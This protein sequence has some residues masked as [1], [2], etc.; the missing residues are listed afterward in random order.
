MGFDKETEEVVKKLNLEKKI[1][2]RYKV[3]DQETGSHVYNTKKIDVFEHLHHYAIWALKSAHECRCDEAISY[4]G[5]MVVYVDFLLN[6]IKEN[7]ANGTIEKE[8]GRVAIDDMDEQVRA[9]FPIE[10]QNEMNHNCNC[11]CKFIDKVLTR[12]WKD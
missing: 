3:L 6:K 12:R 2:Y 1:D 10:L 7:V 8:E 4:F 5:E 11:R 9:N